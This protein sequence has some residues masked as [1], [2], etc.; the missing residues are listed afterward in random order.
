MKLPTGS[1]G[2]GFVNL[3]AEQISRFVQSGGTC[4]EAMYQV[5]VLPTL[6]L[7]LPCPDSTAKANSTH[8]QR[9]MDLLSAGGT[10]QLLLEEG[11]CLQEILFR[12]KKG[13]RRQGES[14]HAREF[15][16]CMR[17]GKVQN[18]LRKLQGSTT[19]SGVL[20]VDDTVKSSN[21]NPVTVREVLQEKH[22]DAV[23][24]TPDVLLSGDASAPNDIM[25]ASLTPGLLRKVATHAEG[26]AG[27]S[28]LDSA[29]WR[30]MCSSYKGASS[31]L[32]EAI[33]ELARLLATRTL[34]VDSLVPFL[35]CRLIV[36]DK[37][38][39]VQPIGV[40]EVLRRIVAKAI[41][42]VAAPDI[43]KACGPLQKCA[44]SPAGIEAA[45]HAMQLIFE[46]PSTECILFV[47]ARNAFNTLNREAALHNAGHLCPTLATILTNSYQSNARLFVAGG[48]ELASCEGTTQGDPLSMAFYALATVPLISHLQRQHSAVRQAWYADDS[49]GAGRLGRV[50]KWWDELRDAAE[51]Y[52]YH[53]NAAK[54][55]LLVKSDLVE[56]A[57][58]QF[59]GT[60]IQIVTGCA[61]YLGSFIG[62]PGAVQLG[63]VRRVG[64]WIEEIERLSVIA[65]TEPHAAHA[66][67]VH[68]LRGR[69][70][71]LF[72]TV[73]IPDE[74]IHALEEVLT[75]KL[76]P[77]LTGC[78]EHSQ[79]LIDLL[80]LPARLGGLALPSFREMGQVELE[81]SRAVVQ[82]QVQDI[83]HQNDP[84]WQNR[85]VATILSEASAARRRVSKSRHEHEEA[86][87]RDVRDKSSPELLRRLDQLAAPGA[88]SWL[89]ALP[90]TDHG[91]HL[92][93][94][95]FRDALAL[96]YGWALRDTP[97]T[98]SCGKAFTPTHAMSCPLGGFPT[99]RHNE[100]RDMLADLV[101]EV[102]ADVA[103][104]PLLA[105]ITGE[106]FLS[107]STNTATDARADIRARGFWT[108]AQAAYFD[109]RVIHPGAASYR[110]Q[111]IAQLLEQHERRKRSE[112]SERVINVDRGTFTPLI[113]TT[114]GGCDRECSVFLKRL[115]GII[116]EKEQKSYG[117]VLAH[118][119]CRLSFALLRSAIMCI[120][121][122]RSAYHR[123][124]NSLR[125]VAMIEG[126]VG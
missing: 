9:R 89:T 115:C 40:G 104:E 1:A 8:L 57:T 110:Q 45:V 118:V 11:R 95:D 13:G 112:Y 108:R 86:C 20:K 105:P 27:P 109:V 116:A 50:R 35:A 51:G 73:P 101:T 72:R 125:E 7:Q 76:L 98:C 88:S 28:G 5:A 21:G 30:R 114:V 68:G 80:R 62:E 46:D 77:A 79:D 48:G 3:V 52:G 36:S 43:L 16:D 99:I 17:N 29:C 23:S 14:D 37:N 12:P 81:N 66:S 87:Y 15:G 93:K 32:C 60:G 96:R 39:G 61:K 103:V 83:L 82:G 65:E 22:P 70:N 63:V 33:A 78:A 31:R 122:P 84:D 75:L 121:G 18:A 58:Q 117:E 97:V 4:T 42:Q 102:C 41:L 19:R 47:D 120:R 74:C 25:F 94:R 119:R 91:F 69:W 34:P 107:A 55:L 85:P 111:S 123:P 6:L 59:N 64:E 100:V 90:V 113:F 49:A 10:I 44:G 53:A 67:I 106:R 26:S 124:E 92:G 71:Y 2:K 126:H 54:T 24:A 38:P 56:E